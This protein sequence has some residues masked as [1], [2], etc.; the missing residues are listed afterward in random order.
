MSGGKASGKGEGWRGGGPALGTRAVPF[1]LHLLQQA[2][3]C[4]GMLWD[5]A[6]GCSRDSAQGWSRDPAQGWSRDPTLGCSGTQHWISL[7]TQLRIAL[8]IQHQD[9]LGIQHQDASAPCAPTLPAS[10]LPPRPPQ[11]LLHGSS[12]PPPQ[13]PPLP[14][15]PAA[16]LHLKWAKW[17]QHPALC[18]GRLREPLP[19]QG[20]ALCRGR[21]LLWQV[22][23]W[24]QCQPCLLVPAGHPARA[25]RP[26][27]GG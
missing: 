19:G 12:S 18:T 9:A 23:P 4:T 20:S 6:L 8:G 2:R 7:W 24:G 22:V 15:A 5:P 11:L 10:K 13:H 16:P 26:W 14:P 1:V 21:T 25:G 3:G 27:L 17:G